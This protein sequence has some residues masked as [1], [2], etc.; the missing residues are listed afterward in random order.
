MVFTIE[1]FTAGSTSKIS[2]LT[3][4]QT[5]PHKLEFGIEFLI[6]KFTRE[7]ELTGVGEDMLAELAGAGEALVAGGAE[8]ALVAVAAQAAL[9]LGRRGLVG[10]RSPR[11]GGHA[12]RRLHRA[13]T[14]LDAAAGPSGAQG[15]V[16]QLRGELRSG[17]RYVRLLRGGRAFPTRLLR[18]LGAALLAF[19]R[20]R[21]RTGHLAIIFNALPLYRWSLI[22]RSGSYGF[23]VALARRDGRK[24]FCHIDGLEALFRIRVTC[25]SR[26]FWSSSLVST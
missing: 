21:W 26:N 14:L 8:V 19:F 2:C 15:H 12:P 6:A 9:G 16:L 5:M 23:E 20:V 10:P 7:G 22:T 24:H 25:F 3:M 11:Q 18:E 4:D 1:G 17:R 13:V